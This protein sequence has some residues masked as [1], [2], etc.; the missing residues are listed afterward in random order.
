MI[1]SITT[2]D[3]VGAAIETVRPFGVDVSS[4][5]E[6]ERGS[7]DPRRIREFVARVRAME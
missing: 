7:K 1:C 5:V 3:N 6:A 2:V 4:G